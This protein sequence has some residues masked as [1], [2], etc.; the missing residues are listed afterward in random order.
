MLVSAVPPHQ[1]NRSY[2]EHPRRGR[3]PLHFMCMVNGAGSQ[4]ER[5][6][7][8]GQGAGLDVGGAEVPVSWVSLTMEA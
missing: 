6:G 8:L 5:S 2:F 4:G 7:K 3:A 1:E